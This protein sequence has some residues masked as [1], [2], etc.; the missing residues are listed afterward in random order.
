MQIISKSLI[1]QMFYIV[2]TLAT[3]SQK[4]KTCIHMQIAEYTKQ[5]DCDRK[6]LLIIL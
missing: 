3:I 4:T 1:F 6:M 2:V 5:K